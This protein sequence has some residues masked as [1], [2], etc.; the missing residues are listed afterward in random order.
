MRRIRRITNWVMV[1]PYRR[2]AS[3]NRRSP[4]V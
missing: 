2:V 4:H 1:S 3:W